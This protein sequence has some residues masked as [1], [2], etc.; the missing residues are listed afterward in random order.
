LRFKAKRISFYRITAPRAPLRTHR[1]APRTAPRA[2]ARTADRMREGGRESVAPSHPLPN[3]LP[4][5]STRR[6]GVLKEMQTP[7]CSSCRPYPIRSS[8]LPGCRSS[9]GPAPR[10]AARGPGS[11]AQW[12]AATGRARGSGRSSPCM[13]IN[14]VD[15]RFK[16]SLFRLRKEPK[17]SRKKQN[18]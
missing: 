14:K 16:A 10:P 18:K 13:L 9:L 4:S 1:S 8:W 3:P 6:V 2:P 11:G 12:P 17:T 15:Y 5:S 7:R